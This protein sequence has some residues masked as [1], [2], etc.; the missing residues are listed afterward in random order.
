MKYGDVG[1][2]GATDLCRL[3]EKTFIGG[4]VGY[5]LWIQCVTVWVHAPSFELT[6]LVFGVTMS[7]AGASVGRFGGR[8]T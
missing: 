1:H 2:G 3:F 7:M 8:W 4:L 6:V 5:T